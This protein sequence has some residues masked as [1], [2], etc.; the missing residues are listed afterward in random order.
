MVKPYNSD[1]VSIISNFAKLSRSE[2]SLLLGKRRGVDW[3]SL[4]YS[5]VLSKLYHLIGQ[6]KTEFST[7]RRS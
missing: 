2:Q 4:S 5:D 7:P 1:S 6:E 3:G